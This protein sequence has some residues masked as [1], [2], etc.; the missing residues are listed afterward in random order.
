MA[1]H[2]GGQPPLQAC[3]QSLLQ[4][5]VLL[6]G[7]SQDQQWKCERH[8]RH[9][10][11]YTQTHIYCTS[12][13]CRSDKPQHHIHNQT[14]IPVST[15]SPR[16]HGQVQTHTE[17]SKARRTRGATLKIHSVVQ[18]N[19]RH[20]RLERAEGPCDGACAGVLIYGVLHHALRT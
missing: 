20:E 6:T 2:G 5:L 12:L 9:D 10:Q 4:W 17:I 18:H 19:T 13:W 7:A 15:A 3:L 16:P 1:V 8:Q 14:H 11:E